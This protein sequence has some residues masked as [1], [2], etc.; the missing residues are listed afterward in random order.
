MDENYGGRLSFYFVYPPDEDI[1]GKKGRKS[2][3]ISVEKKIK[4]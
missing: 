3:K 1:K 4:I 2:V